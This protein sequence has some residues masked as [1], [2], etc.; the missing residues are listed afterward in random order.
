MYVGDV[1]WWKLYTFT[2]DYQVPDLTAASLHKTALAIQDGSASKKYF[3]N[4]FLG[5]TNLECDASCR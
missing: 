3:R 4:Y 1:Q 2:E 5:A